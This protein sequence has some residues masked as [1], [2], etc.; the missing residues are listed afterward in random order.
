MSNASNESL[1]EHAADM[2][3]YW[4]GTMHARIIQRDIDA[5]DLEAL[6]YHVDVAHAEM[7]M[8]EDEGEATDVL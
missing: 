4:S 2:L 6:A 3:D 8:Q 5:N 7:R 1:M